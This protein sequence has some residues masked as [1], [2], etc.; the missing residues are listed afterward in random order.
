MPKEVRVEGAIIGSLTYLPFWTLE[1]DIWILPA[2][3]SISDF[4][5]YFLF[6]FFG[7]ATRVQFLVLETRVWF[8][9]V[10]ASVRFFILDTSDTACFIGTNL[11]V[12]ASTFLVTFSKLELTLSFNGSK[13]PSGPAGP[14]GNKGSPGMKV[15]GK[16]NSINVVPR[17][18]I[19]T[20]LWN[21]EMIW[22][23]IMR[24]SYEMLLKQW[25]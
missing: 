24:W 16:L 6:F 2:S 22:N 14:D 9:I 21:Y 11:L 10:D 25:F 4:K 5:H 1:C 19:K 17:N 3:F 18:V 23:V 20:M 12:K 15:N 7:L 13:G 8:F